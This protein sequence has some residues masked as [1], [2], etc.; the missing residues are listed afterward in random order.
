MT[1]LTSYL[2]PT[3]PEGLESVIELALDLMEA[4]S[5]LWLH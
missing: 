4:P 5:I 2:L 1:T 3:P